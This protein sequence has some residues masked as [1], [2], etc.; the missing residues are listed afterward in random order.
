MNKKLIA[1]ALVL[2][3]AVGGLFAAVPSTTF[4][5]ATLTGVVGTYLNH[6]F[7]NAVGTK[8]QATAVNSG[9]AFATGNSPVLVYGFDAKSDTAFKTVMTVSSFKRDVPG[10]TE[11]VDIA[12]VSIKVGNDVPVTHSTVTDA[13]QIDVLKYTTSEVNTPVEKEATITVN[14]GTVDP[15]LPS[16]DYVST[17][18]ISVTALT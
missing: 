5:E 16:G 11:K 1:L 8:Y 6:G 15:G 18:S 12:S 4:V 3:I 13:T 9:N 14:P 7:T 2:F 17:L 10:A